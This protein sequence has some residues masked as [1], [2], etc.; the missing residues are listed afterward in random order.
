VRSSCEATVSVEGKVKTTSDKETTLT[1][2][3]LRCP[4]F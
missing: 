1:E 4:R 2:E 3:Q